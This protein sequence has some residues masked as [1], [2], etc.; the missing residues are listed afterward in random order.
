MVIPVPPKKYPIGQKGFFYMAPKDTEAQVGLTAPEDTKRGYGLWR[1]E[2]IHPADP[3]MDEILASGDLITDTKGLG[4]RYTPVRGSYAVQHFRVNDP[5]KFSAALDVAFPDVHDAVVRLVAEDIRE[6][7]FAALKDW[8]VSSALPEPFE[9]W[10]VRTEMRCG[11][12]RPDICVRHPEGGQIELEVVNTHAPESDRLEKAWG[13]GHIVLSMR[14]RDV[15]EKIVF[16]AG[17]GVVPEDDELRALLKGKRF[18][19]SGRSQMPRAVAQ[20]WKDLNLAAYAQTLLGELTQAWET[21]NA[22]IVCPLEKVISGEKVFR[23]PS[24]RRGRIRAFGEAFQEPPPADAKELCGL[25]GAALRNAARDILNDN[26]ELMSACRA[27]EQFCAEWL[28][29]SVQPESVRRLRAE[30]LRLLDA[31]YAAEMR[32]CA[33]MKDQVAAAG[34]SDLRRHVDLERNDIFEGYDI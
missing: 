12:Y 25:W 8:C 24:A 17:R 1:G 14:I 28:R 4:L 16:S 19:L 29:A 30:C 33:G 6:R 13:A 23:R 7:G 26:H 3:R 15:V 10:E 27:G 5:D 32:I 18:R 31:A 34:R 20:K 2:V 21:Y 11:G 22:E 9:V